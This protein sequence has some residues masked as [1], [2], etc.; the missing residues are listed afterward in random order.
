MSL[1]QSF[2][3]FQERGIMESGTLEHGITKRD[4]VISSQIPFQWK[5]DHAFSKYPNSLSIVI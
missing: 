2:L 3:F 4:I 5:R 1:K